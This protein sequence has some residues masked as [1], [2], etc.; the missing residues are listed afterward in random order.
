VDSRPD[1]L[2]GLAEAARVMYRAPD[3]PS[4]L[5]TAVQA[6]KLALPGVDHVGISVSYRDGRVETVAATDQLVWDL[7]QLQYELR[8]GPCM[9]AIWE[10]GVVEVDNLAS[11][12][13]RWPRFVPRAVDLGLR[14]Q[15]GLRLY[16]DEQTLGGLNL[17][18]TSSDT[19]EA[20][21]CEA[22]ELF[23]AHMALEMGHVRRE[24]NLNSAVE[25][26]KLI[27]Q[28]IGL[29]MERFQLDEN[30]AF[31]YLAR[32][33]QHSNIK[34]RDV[35]AEM[36]QQTNEN[37]RPPSELRSRARTDG[38]GEQGEVDPVS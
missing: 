36:V 19:I 9:E 14:A 31:Q 4:T 3:L 13:S 18:S 5:N 15:M 12:E 29:V 11:H 30:R 7:D 16:V 10:S 38:A 35:A 20:G 34:L 25:T 21:T 24:E 17:Y 27:G 22:A 23:A 37:N 33:S 6:A 26:R 32:V 2:A 28:A 8:E 1:I